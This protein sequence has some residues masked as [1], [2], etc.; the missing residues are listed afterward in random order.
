MSPD[1]QRGPQARGD[2]LQQPVAPGVAEGVVDGLEVVEVQE[3]HRERPAVVAPATERVLHAIAEQRPV[4]EVGDRVV[5]RLVG[6]LLLEL[7]ALGDVAQVDDDSADGG[8]VQKVGD[9]AFGVQQATI[10]VADA[11]LERLRGLRGEREQ[12]HE[13]RL[14]ERLIRLRHIAQ[15]SLADEISRARNRGSGESKGSRT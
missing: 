3:Q 1:A 4:R 7:L 6:E 15:E 12:H 13:R 10:A 14:E 2:G 9:Q 8:L 5:E 11:E